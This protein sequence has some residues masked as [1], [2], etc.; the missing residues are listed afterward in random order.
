MNTDKEIVATNKVKVTISEKLWA[1]IK[2]L[3]EKCP[4]N[5]EWSALLI[6]KAVNGS[7][8]DLDNLE[9]EAEGLFPMDYGDATFTSFEGGE[10]WL[11]CFYQYPQINPISPEPGWYLGKIH[12]HHNMDVFHSPTDK[13]DLYENAPKLPM[14]LSMIVNYKMEVDC[15]LAIAMEVKETMLQRVTYKLKGWNKKKN[16]G[17]MEK[18]VQNRNMVYLF[19]C[20]VFYIAPDVDEWLVEQCEYLKNKVKPII[21]T[22]SYHGSGYKPSTHYIDTNVGKDSK[23]PTVRKFVKERIIARL[24]DLIQL[25]YDYDEITA[26]I[27]NKV[28]VAVPVNDRA[29]YIKAIKLYFVNSWYLTTFLNMNVDEDEAIEGVLEAI[30][31][32]NG[33]IVGVIKQAFNELKESD[34][35]LWTV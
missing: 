3:H 11:K 25:G 17:K 30:T 12:S 29:K 31:F 14:F 8:N 16:K 15:E 20:E 21:H 2:F 18:A 13:G 19:K 7:I 27:V 35:E 26:K 1:Q 33:W 34:R 32:H 4:R 10:D 5:K 23:V 22:S 24:G 6:W 28:D 9:I